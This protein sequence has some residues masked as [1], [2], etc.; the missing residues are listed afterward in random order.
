MS[1][2]RSAA[3]ARNELRVLRRDPMPLVVLLVMPLIMAPLFRT[4]FRATLLLG[5]HPHASGSDFAIPAQMVQFGF[6][7]APF[8]GFLFFREHIWKTWSRLRASPASPTEIVLGKAM[9]MVALGGLQI[10]VLLIVG[11]LALDLHLHGEL[12]PI[13]AVAA[14][15]MCCAVAIG[16]ALTAVLRTSQQMNAVGFLG[17]TVLGAIGGALVPLN[18]L[19]HWIRHLSPATPQYWAMRATRDLIIDGRAANSAILPIVVLAMFTSGFALIA[20]RRLRFDET[21]LGWS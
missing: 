6:F 10:T 13:L 19:P 15:Y 8:T 16:V 1:P 5:G 2:R 21:K 12:L 3:V 9:P 11:V 18:T 20:I 7:L 17:A 14:V 4:T